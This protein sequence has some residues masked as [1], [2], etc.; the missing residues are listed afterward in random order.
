MSEKSNATDK[1]QNE[2]EDKRERQYAFRDELR[3]EKI[4]MWRREDEMR[5]S[6]QCRLF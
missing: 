5:N 6:R 3:A 1:E 2:R 4:E